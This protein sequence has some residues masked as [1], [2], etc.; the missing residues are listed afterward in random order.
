MR[1]QDRDAAVFRRES[2][3]P[4]RRAVRIRRVGRRNATA[5]VDE[6]QEGVRDRRALV[7]S[8]NESGGTGAAAQPAGGMVIAGK[9]GTSQ[10]RRASEEDED[11][12]NIPWELRDHALFVSYFP[13]EAPR[14]AIAAV[15]EHGGGGGTAAAPVVKD[16]IDYVLEDDPAKRPYPPVAP[17]ATKSAHHAGRTGREG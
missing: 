15:V 5:I 17:V 8:V 4:L 11:D 2:R 6:P 16:I 13:A 3:D 9:T 10:V 1:H 12:R 7:A 14:Y